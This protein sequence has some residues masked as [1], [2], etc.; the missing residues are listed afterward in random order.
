MKHI[1]EIYI[2]GD[3]S[4][5]DE[6]N[7]LNQ[8][9][10]ASLSL[11]P[12]GLVLTDTIQKVKNYT[13]LKTLFDSGSDKTFI[14]RRILPKGATTKTVDALPINTLNGIDSINQKVVLDGL[15]LPEFSATQR[16]DKKIFAYVFDQSNSPYDLV[17][18]LDVL[19][20]L[21]IDISCSTQNITWMDQIVSWKPKSY[22]DDSHLEKSESYE[23]HCFF[24][25]TEDDFD[26]WIESHTTPSFESWAVDIKESKYEK[27]DTDY[28]AKQQIH[29]N[30][31][32]QSDL[33][34]VLKDFTK[35]FSGKLGCYPGHKVHLELEENAQPCHTRPYPVPENHKRFSK[36]N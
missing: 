16:I 19:I 28:A 14:N 5:L 15:I 23:A 1:S 20:P 3:E 31:S 25:N 13:P 26:E 22:F 7:L 36:Q 2:Q 32:Q 8:D 21:G 29:L 27:V 17:L 6:L 35:L 33:A 9:A 11:R 34:Y 4:K 30:E 18:G 10:T 24:V 12:I